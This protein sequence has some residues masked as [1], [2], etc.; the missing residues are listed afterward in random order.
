MDGD[1]TLDLLDRLAA[2]KIIN[3]LVIQV[4]FQFSINATE[5]Q[6][7]GIICNSCKYLELLALIIIYDNKASGNYKSY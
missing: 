6:G 4:P 2:F 5:K 7:V 3:I 1:H